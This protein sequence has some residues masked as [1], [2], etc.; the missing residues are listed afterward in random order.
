MLEQEFLLMYYLGFTYSDLRDIPLPY[1][2]WF[3][4]RIQREINKHSDESGDGAYTKGAHDHHPEVRAT[5]G[6][7]PHAPARLRRFT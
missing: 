1:R 6:Q 4:E 5:R 3:I 2:K 7:R